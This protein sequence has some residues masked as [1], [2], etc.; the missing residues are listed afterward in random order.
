MTKLRKIAVIIVAGGRG[1]RAAVE[2]ASVPKQ[3]QN[4]LGKPV[5]AWTIQAFLQRADI[6]CILPVIGMNDASLFA[7]MGLD[8]DPRL[9]TPV[10]GGTTRQLSVLAG[11]EAL[12]GADVTHVLVHDGARPV[13]P[14]EVIFW[15]LD[16]LDHAEGAL[17]ALAIADTLKHSVDGI[18]VDGTHERNGL[19]AAQ[20]PQGFD[21]GKLLRAHRRAK[22]S[23]ENFTDDSSI[24]ERAG[25]NVVFSKGDADNIKITRPEDFKRAEDILARRQGMTGAG[26]AGFETRN[27]SG[28]D[29]HPFVAGKSVTLGGVLIPHTAS[30]KGHSDADAA[31]HVLTDAVLGALAEGDIGMHFPP[32]D[33]RWRGASSTTFLQFA[34]RRVAERGGRIVNLDLTIVCEYPKIGPHVFAM[35]ESI[36]R[37][38]GIDIS[39]VSVKATT[40][41][42]MGFIGRQEGL[43]TLGAASVEVPRGT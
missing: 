41:E 33:A 25:L 9:L 13:V 10:N 1:E 37:I 21:F 36:A 35:R 12:S 30:L 4:L 23:G 40:S 15:V 3:Y 5:L 29:V 18:A 32:D 39:R 22:A 27:G 7:S 2:N 26:H 20:T 31:L 38:C 34:T 17:P 6:D 28:F 42:R 43:A 24:A 11:L 14:P 19:Y 16:A 8:D